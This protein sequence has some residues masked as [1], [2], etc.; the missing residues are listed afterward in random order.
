MAVMIPGAGPREHTVQSREGEMY[1]ALAQLPDSFYVVH[2]YALTRVVD[3][4]LRESEF[5]FVVFHKD[6]GLMCIEAKSGSVRYEG[7][8]WL[9]GS[10]VPM[11]GGGPFQQA[12]NA[13]Y[14]LYDSFEEKR[15]TA[16]REKCKFLHAVWFPSVAEWQLRDIEFPSEAERRL[17]LT[18]E[19]LADPEMKLRS[20]FSLDVNSSRTQTN[21]NEDEAD[22]IVRR[23]LCPQF[24]VVPSVRLKYDL[25]NTKFIQLLKSQKRVLDFLEDQRFAVVNGVAGSGK[26]LIA[27]ERARRVAAGG[28]RVLF[29]CFNAML[30]DDVAKRCEDEPLIDVRTVAG[31]ATKECGSVDYEA[32]G[33]KLIS[34]Y[35]GGFPYKH[36]VIDEGQDFAVEAI[37]RAHILETLHDLS[38]GYGGTMFLFYDR[39][40]LVQGSDMP[41]FIESAD[42]K[43]TLYVNCRNTKTIAECSFEALGS[44]RGCDVLEEAATGRNPRLFASAD[45][46]KQAA[47]VDAK[48]VE[49]KKRGLTDIVVLTCRTEEK[50]CLASCLRSGKVTTWRM[51]KV[52]FTTCR[53]FK[54]LEADAV[55]L[56]DVDESVW[57]PEYDD[58]KY[59][60]RPGLLFYTGA[61]R[62]RLELAI[63][64]DMDE[65]ECIRVLE[66]LGST[67]KRRPVRDL[68]VKLRAMPDLL[69]G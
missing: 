32:L 6:L 69:N 4:V 26:T 10:G 40:Q 48:I 50:T 58:P 27:I 68:A 37:E 2:S 66:T 53:K 31:L 39:N 5:D 54:G 34:Y 45:P 30:K 25:A 56:V 7:G 9:Y 57:K 8:N 24:N 64:C 41:R 16:I 21:L 35:D 15:M 22:A 28:D 33:D 52:P 13:K 44:E 38:A 67:A 46:Q 17:V 20:I 19:D 3:Q 61:S 11:K 47:Y 1:A 62:A 18:L 65:N 59:A 63:V 14:R 12:A 43:L 36:I 55:I 29:L 51:T 42:S 49:Y 23:V 60:A